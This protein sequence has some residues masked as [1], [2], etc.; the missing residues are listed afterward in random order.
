MKTEFLALT[1]YVNGGLHVARCLM[2]AFL[3][4]IS[5]F[6]LQHVAIYA[7]A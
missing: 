7:Y 2:V 1:V 6:I 4:S 3:N 5:K